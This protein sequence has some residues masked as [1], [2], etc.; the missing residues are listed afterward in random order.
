MSDPVV[1]LSVV[2]HGQV[3]LTSTLLADIAEV[4]TL[5]LEVIYTRNIPE[6][7]LEVP[8]ALRQRTTII[9]N[10]SP[11]GFGANHNAAFRAATAPHFCVLNPD[12]RLSGDPFP[13]LV[14]MCR[15]PRIGVVAPKV[16]SPSG[17]VENS[18]RDYPHPFSIAARALGLRDERPTSTGADVF[19]PDW[20]GGMF[21]LLRREVYA[22]VGGF[23]ERFFMYYE[24]VDLCARLR[25]LGREVACVPSVPVIHDARRASHH[26]LRHRS[27][28]LRSMLRFFIS[29]V[30]ARAL[31]RKRRT[32]SRQVPRA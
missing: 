11:K 23:D 26:D 31:L 21:M 2:S 22:E 15:D 16:L 29:P 17:E 5:P 10:P 18:A 24:D 28:H 12:V 32:A 25:L 30:F 13:G 1:S 20:V 9:D 8:N 14:E 27:W 7:A 19:Y 3:E 6:P 4:C